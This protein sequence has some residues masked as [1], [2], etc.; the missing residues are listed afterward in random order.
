MQ[1]KT[2]FQLAAA[3]FVISAFIVEITATEAW[4]EAPIALATRAEPSSWGARS[5]AWISRAR[6]SIRR[7]RPPRRS[8]EAILRAD[9]AA[10]RLGVGATASTSVASPL[11]RSSKAT[12]AAG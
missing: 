6:S 10:P 9:S 8:A 1:L 11:A 2:R 3:S 12:S 7:C 4:T 5:A